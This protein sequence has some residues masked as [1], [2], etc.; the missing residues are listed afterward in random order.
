MFSQEVNLILIF[1]L[2]ATGAVELAKGESNQLSQTIRPTTDEETQQRAALGVIRRLIA[3]KADNVAI[4]I[5]FNLLGNY[6]KVRIRRQ[7]KVDE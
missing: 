1:L 4:K 3:D 2:L 7:E 6:F 5:N